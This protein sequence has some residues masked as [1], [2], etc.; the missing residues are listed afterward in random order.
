VQ[1]EEPGGAQSPAIDWLMIICG[2]ICGYVDSYTLM[3][4]NVYTSFMSGNTVSAGMHA[5]QVRFAMAW[6]ALLPVGPFVVG[7][8]CG[9]LLQPGQSSRERSWVFCLIAV[10]LTASV[11]TA[12]GAW[13][14]WLCIGGLSLAMG[15][16]NTTITQ[17]GGQS[18]SLGFVTGD[19]KSMAAHLARGV[20][21][22][23]VAHPACRSDTHW[24]RA[25]TLASI[26]SAF[27]LGAML[28]AALASRL[29]V[30][31]LLVPASALL[32]A[33]TTALWPEITRSAR[34]HINP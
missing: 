23:P 7:V 32:I 13:P 9:T 15:M 8:F 12:W 4:F 20:A 28:G 22:T 10:L 2:V 17:V 27:L 34:D 14:D 18:L 25:G 1:G 6:H 33:A 5:G 26:W 21:G 24:R 31:T 29:M 11:L 3:T 16:M 30:W 19:L